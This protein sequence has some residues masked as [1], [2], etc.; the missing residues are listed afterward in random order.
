MKKNVK[1]LLVVGGIVV[2]VFGIVI[3]TSVILIYAMAKVVSEYIV[4][5]EYN[6]KE[7]TESLTEDDFE[8]VENTDNEE[9]EE[10]S[11]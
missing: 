9:G 5:N 10:W 8:E 7:D 4:Y 3:A 2:S 6:R 1:G 11:E